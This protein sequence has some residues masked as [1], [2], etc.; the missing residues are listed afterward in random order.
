MA[1]RNSGRSI[2]H[3]ARVI[4]LYRLPSKYKKTK[5]GTHLPQDEP[6]STKN[7]ATSPTMINAEEDSGTGNSEVAALL[8]LIPLSRGSA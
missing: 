3:Q 5:K 1:N 6:S 7:M 8:P 2:I 4:F